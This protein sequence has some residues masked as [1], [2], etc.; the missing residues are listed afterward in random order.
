M[1]R[2]AALA[3]ATSVL[4]KP[5]PRDF[6]PRDVS[7]VSSIGQASPSRVRRL[8]RR[9]LPDEDRYLRLRE[10]GIHRPAGPLRSEAIARAA[11]VQAHT[12]VLDEIADAKDTGVVGR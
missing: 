1:G 12:R 10:V 7:T 2:F 4:E 9:T 5:T 8:T 3:A 11:L 6:V